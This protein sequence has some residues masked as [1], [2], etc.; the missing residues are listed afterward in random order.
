MSIRYLL[1]SDICIYAIKRRSQAL[2]KQLD[3]AA[4]QCSLS[5]I[6]Y[7]ELCYGTAR[8]ER[9]QE[10][11]ANIDALLQVV[12]VLPLPLDA[13]KHYGRI[14]SE[15]EKSGRIIGGNDLW[16]AAHALASHLTLVTN[17]ER[18]FRRVRGLKVENWSSGERDAST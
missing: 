13:A 15:L 14:R 7:G 17:N 8:S 5:I 16:I 9:A 6:S 11:M 18:E 3:A 2:L 12:P 4:S 10:A 1:D